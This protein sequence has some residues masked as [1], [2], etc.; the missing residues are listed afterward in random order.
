LRVEIFND[1]I[2]PLL[3]FQGDRHNQE[4]HDGGGWTNGIF[5]IYEENSFGALEFEGT[6]KEIGF[7]QN[8]FTNTNFKYADNV[9]TNE[10][11]KNSIG[12]PCNFL[13][14]FKKMNSTIIAFSDINNFFNSNQQLS[15][16]KTFYKRYGGEYFKYSG[17]SFENN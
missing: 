5:A 11:L 14:L 15:Y 10:V 4:V 9:I 16:G 8:K 17:I 6:K 13:L 7:L 1:L 2:K 12:S 3:N